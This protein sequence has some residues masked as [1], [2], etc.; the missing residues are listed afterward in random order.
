[1]LAFQIRPEQAMQEMLDF[2]QKLGDG[3]KNLMELDGINVGNTPKEIVYQEDKLTLYRYTPFVDKPNS[4]PIIIV[5]AL[6]NRPYMTDLQED[7]SLVKNLLQQGQDVYLIDWGYP[8]QSDR[9]L[10]LDDYINIFRM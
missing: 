9:Y 8:D 2:N 4:T 10:T 7:R 5:Y 6:V 1:M 3:I